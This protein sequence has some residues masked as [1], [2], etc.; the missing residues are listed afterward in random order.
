MGPMSHE[1]IL[2]FYDPKHK[3]TW[4]VFVNNNNKELVF[5]L[6]LRLWHWFFALS[7]IASFVIAKTIDDESSTYSWHMLIGVFMLFLVIQRIIWSGLEG[8]LFRSI[9][10]LRGI[11][12]PLMALFTLTLAISGI[13]MSKN[14]H[15]HFFEEVH[16]FAAHGFLI[17]IMIHIGGVVYHELKHRDGMISAMIT[18]KKVLQKNENVLRS[19]SI[20][21]FLAV[22]IF[23]VGFAFYLSTQYNGNRRTLNLFGQ[24]LVLGEN[25]DDNDI[26]GDDEKKEDELEDEGDRDDEDD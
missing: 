7:F 10:S 25:D 9:A 5:D 14:L 2:S 1:K 8:A 16:E 3:K 22:L 11:K 19:N 18:G 24:I 15:K 26:G 21:K 12:F 20:Y 13:M 6:A 17:L 23:I 4:E